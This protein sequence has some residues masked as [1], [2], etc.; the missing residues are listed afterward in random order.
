MCL[1]LEAGMKLR[2]HH[3]EVLLFG[4][5]SSRFPWAF[6]HFCLTLQAPDSVPSAFVLLLF[7]LFLFSCVFDPL[8][9]GF[10]LPASG[11]LSS[12]LPGNHSPHRKIRAKTHAWPECP[13]FQDL[14]FCVWVTS[15]TLWAWGKACRPCAILVEASRAH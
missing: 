12:V 4:T 8:A 2:C 1:P 10:L 9:T 7:S 13:A 3:T 14:L 5:Q 15:L 11:P 6:T